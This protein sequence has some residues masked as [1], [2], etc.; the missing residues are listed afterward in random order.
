MC[1]FQKFSEAEMRKLH[2]KETDKAFL[3]YLCDS[4][5]P[6][7]KWMVNWNYAYCLFKQ[8]YWSKKFRNKNEIERC[9]FMLSTKLM[10]KC[11]TMLSC[12]IAILASVKMQVDIPAIWKCMKT[13]K[14]QN[15]FGSF[16]HLFLYINLACL[17][18]CLFVSNNVKTAVPIG[19]KFS[20][21]PNMAPGK[22]Y[23]WS[24]FKKISCQ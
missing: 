2:F 24:K 16:V 23:E 8:L 11:F 6:R 22:V 19:P 12:K 18:V 5:M 14:I 7:Y 3:R 13:I 9:M 10:I 4:D 15:I 17:S 20:V 21:G 1:S